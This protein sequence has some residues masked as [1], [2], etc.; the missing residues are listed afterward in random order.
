M[1]KQT[2]ECYLAKKKT[3]I[4]PVTPHHAEEEGRGYWDLVRWTP[5]PWD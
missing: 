5:T 2:Q 4:S 3:K 1:L